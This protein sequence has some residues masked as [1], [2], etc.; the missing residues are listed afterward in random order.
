MKV[1]SVRPFVCPS[2][3]S[4]GRT[5][6]RVCCCAPGGQEI[7]I[8][9]CTAGVTLS[10]DAGSWTDLLCML[11]ADKAGGAEERDAASATL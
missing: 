10:C 7:S 2:V 3:P 4:F 8:D 11:H 9:C 1:S 6:R 5:L